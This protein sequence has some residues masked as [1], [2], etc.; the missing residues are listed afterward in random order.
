MDKFSIVERFN[1]PEDL[2]E[3]LH[4]IQAVSL[5][6]DVLCCG[7]VTGDCE[8]CRQLE[9]G[10]VCFNCF[11]SQL[12][13]SKSDIGTLNFGYASDQKTKI[14]KVDTLVAELKRAVAECEGLAEFLEDYNIIKPSTFVTEF[15]SD[16]HQRPHITLYMAQTG[17]NNFLLVHPAIGAMMRWLFENGFLLK[18]ISF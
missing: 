16:I 7:Y 15:H 3:R 9:E 2:L 8:N 11:K 6:Q 14:T 18:G 13:D 1:S 4:A 5:E 10:Y 17:N 12:M